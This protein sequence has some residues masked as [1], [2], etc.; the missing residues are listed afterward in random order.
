MSD[1]E[2]NG[3]SN[4]PRKRGRRDSASSVIPD[5]DSAPSISSDSDSFDLGD[6]DAALEAANEETTARSHLYDRQLVADPMARDD[7]VRVKLIPRSEV[8]ANVDLSKECVLLPDEGKMSKS[9]VTKGVAYEQT[10]REA[11]DLDVDPKELWEQ[12]MEAADLSTRSMSGIDYKNSAPIYESPNGPQKQ[13]SNWKNPRQNG[14]YLPK[15]IYRDQD[16]QFWASHGKEDQELAGKSLD[17]LR[18]QKSTDIWVVSER[19]QPQH[20]DDLAEHYGA[21]YAKS[22]VGLQTGAVRERPLPDAT[23]QVPAKVGDKVYHAAKRIDAAPFID[24]KYANHAIGHALRNGSLGEKGTS[25]ENV[26]LY[27]SNSAQD[28]NWTPSYLKDKQP[29]RYQEIDA[30]FGGALSKK[31]FEK[32]HVQASELPSRERGKLFV[33]DPEG[34]GSTAQVSHERVEGLNGRKLTEVYP[35]DRI[36]VPSGKYGATTSL[37]KLLDNKDR[38]I[39]QHVADIAGVEAREGAAKP[40]NIRDIQRPGQDAAAKAGLNERPREPHTASI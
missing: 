24:G 11:K 20:V 17:E 36:Q 9:F 19:G 30:K 35:P 23:L 29:A 8:S 10:K 15:L 28:S 31:L 1:V 22:R 7:D 21:H 37:D 39:S 27:I 18:A 14:K 4:N 26:R 34:K 40:N 3:P 12:K 13:A 38:A 5:R 2:D 6:L 25:T 33:V 16:G 32:D